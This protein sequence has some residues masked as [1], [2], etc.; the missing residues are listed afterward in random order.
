MVSACLL[1]SL[2]LPPVLC[3]VCNDRS[4][5]CGAWAKDGECISNANYVRAPPCPSH[6]PSDAIS[7]SSSVPTPHSAD[8]PSPPPS[9][10]AGLLLA[11][12]SCSLTHL[13]PLVPS[14]NAFIG[15]FACAEQMAAM[16]PLSC[17]VCTHECEDLDESCAG[18]AVDGHCRSN[19]IFMLKT[20]PTSCGACSPSCKDTKFQCEAWGLMGQ[21]NDN[22]G[23]MA[24]YC[25]VTCG[26]CKNAC[27][28][29]HPDCPNWA[30]GSECHDNPGFMYKTCPFSCN[31][32]SDGPTCMDKNTT[33]CHIWADS[34]E[35]L[36][37]PMAVVKECP[38]TCGAC[39]TSCMDHDENC[40]GWA[41]QAKCESRAAARRL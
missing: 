33:Q 5:H 26:V 2:L 18:W 4:T 29:L 3:G 20:C 27:K 22:P 11:P 40:H 37:N 14:L 15:K 41:V 31:V 39:T 7:I 23:F 38:E 16:C 32:C 19:P 28:D 10:S 1:L 9:H 30:T 25:P 12:P 24:R 36:H 17:S 35:C 8:K 13:A 34:G 21:C 6:P